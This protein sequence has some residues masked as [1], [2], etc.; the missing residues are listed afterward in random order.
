M[1]DQPGNQT[2]NTP[3]VSETE[4]RATKVDEL[5]D[6]AKEAG[7]RGASSMRKDDL[8]HAVADAE[9]GKADGGAGG[10]GGGQGGGDAGGRAEGRRGGEDPR[11]RGGPGRGGEG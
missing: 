2:P 5:R 6:Q 10:N 1:A 3:D 9:Q 8:V 11:G 4:L 7:V